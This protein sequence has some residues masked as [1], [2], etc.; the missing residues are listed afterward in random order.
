MCAAQAAMNN[1]LHMFTE[2]DRALMEDRDFESS[3]GSTATSAA[4]DAA[5]A[6]EGAEAFNRYIRLS[7]NQDGVQPLAFDCELGY[8]AAERYHFLNVGYSARK[9][10]VT[11]TVTDETRGGSCTLQG[12]HY[13][14]RCCIGGG[15]E[16]GRRG[17][18][19]M[20]RGALKAAAQLEPFSACHEVCLTDQS[21]KSGTCCADF[22]MITHGSLKTWYE[23]KFDAVVLP[24]WERRLQDTRDALSKSVDCDSDTFCAVLL[25]AAQTQGLLPWWRRVERDAK[26]AF[27]SHA[28]VRPA[29]SWAALLASLVLQ[30]NDERGHMAKIMLTALASGQICNGWTSSKGVG[31]SIPMQTVRGWDDIEISLDETHYS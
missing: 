2:E 21:S 3:S 27:E 22:H 24:A 12:V 25:G 16:A 28:A 15:M 19:P 29:C 5:A 13:S 14:E 7:I 31:W 8:S 1:I 20:L 18:V 9:P 23:E 11:V 4:A 10:C 30:F 6:E 26:R 17:T